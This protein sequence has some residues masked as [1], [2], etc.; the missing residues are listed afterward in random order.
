[1]DMILDLIEQITW[2][3]KILPALHKYN[4]KPAI[5]THRR[6]Y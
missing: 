1:M 6:F 2:Q 4:K 3:I 5:K